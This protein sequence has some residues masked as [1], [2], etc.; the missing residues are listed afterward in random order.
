MWSRKLFQVSFVKRLSSHEVLFKLKVIMGNM[1]WSKSSSE[2]LPLLSNVLHGVY[3]RVSVTGMEEFLKVKLGFRKSSLY[4]RAA[5]LET[6]CTF[7]VSYDEK[8]QLWKMTYT[9][10]HF[11]RSYVFKT[12]KFAKAPEKV[13]RVIEKPD[14][15]LGIKWMNV[16]RNKKGNVFLFTETNPMNGSLTILR[17]FSNDWK[18]MKQLTTLKGSNVMCEEIFEKISPN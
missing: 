5:S 16:A 14:Y 6:I 15:G 2:P 4:K 7:E 10:N 12:P 13:D 17:T 1:I 8:N 18:T 11:S 9:R 3:K